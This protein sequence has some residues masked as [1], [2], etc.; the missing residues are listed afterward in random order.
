M[1]LSD[2]DLDWARQQGLLIVEPDQIH[3]AGEDPCSVGAECH[4]LADVTGQFLGWELMP[5]SE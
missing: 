4:V 5:V 1:F 2:R 3:V